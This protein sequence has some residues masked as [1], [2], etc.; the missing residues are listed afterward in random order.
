M[1][2][3]LT[4]DNWLTKIYQ[5]IN[6]MQQINDEITFHRPATATEPE[7]DLHVSVLHHVDHTILNFKLF[8][9]KQPLAEIKI[10]Q[11]ATS[12][13]IEDCDARLTKAGMLNTFESHFFQTI[14]NLN[15]V[16]YATTYLFSGQINVKTPL[17]QTK[18]NVIKQL[19]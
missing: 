18:Q 11:N 9:Q 17:L 5:T 1:S 4:A 8:T 7:A 19:H 6:E 15:I 3:L 16:S 14:Q 10:I 2:N 12:F 13:Q